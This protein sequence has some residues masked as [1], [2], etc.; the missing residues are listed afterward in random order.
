MTG[1]AKPCNLITFLSDFGLSGGYAA[2]CEA[3]IAALAPHVRVLHLS[4]EIEPGD[5]RWGSMVLARVAQ[6]GPSCIHLAVVDP[7]VGTDRHPLIAVSGRGDLLVGPDNG[8][9][10]PA[11][12]ALEGLKE[13]WVLDPDQVRA[14]AKLPGGR[15]SPTFHARDI[16]A[17]AAA[18]LAT[19]TGL[20]DLAHP[21]DVSRLVRPLEP[22]VETLGEGFAAEVVEVDPFGNV[23][24]AAL[25]D[26]GLFPSPSVRVEIEGGGLPEWDARLVRTFGQLPSG[27]LGVYRDSWGHVALA[28]NGASAAELLS[29]TR[30]MMV[31]VVARGV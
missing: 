26:E 7:G 8:L 15:I 30:G 2:A 12:N 23:G 25:F 22:A 29:V 19:G 17:P 13:A 20:S 3:T 27:E 10:V 16:F 14:F 24:L 31:R 28:L 18:L 5:I 11:A 4:H 6:L 9:L 1:L 21:L